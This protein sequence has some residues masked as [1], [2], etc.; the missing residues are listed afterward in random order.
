VTSDTV[1]GIVPDTVYRSALEREAPPFYYVPLAQN[2]EAG[3][4]LHVRTAGGDPLVLLSAVQSVVHDV[5]PRVAVARPQRLR[6][7]FDQSISSQRM[8][9]RWSGRSAPWRCSSPRSGST[10]SWSTSPHTARR[11]RHPSRARRRPASIFGLILGEGLRLV[12]DRHRH[13]LDRGVRDDALHPD[14]AVRRRSGGCATFARGEP[15]PHGNRDPRV[16]HPARRAM[17][18]DPVVAFRAR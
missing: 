6:E 2:Y 17:K 12:G 14:A 5:D 4:A 10:G 18:V 15:H 9:A 7:V 1:V 16:P 8:M 11:D 13:R 3:V